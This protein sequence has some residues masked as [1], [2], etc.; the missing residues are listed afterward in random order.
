MKRYKPLYEG[1]KQAIQ[2]LQKYFGERTKEVISI[3]EK[4]DPTSPQ[5]KY[6]EIFAKII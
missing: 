6:L 1:K 5:N 4:L 3:F 2:I